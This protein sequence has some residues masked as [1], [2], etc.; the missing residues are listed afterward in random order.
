MP[1]DQEIRR[2][3]E[4]PAISYWLREALLSALERDPVD[5]ANDAGLLCVVLDKRLE[6]IL[7]TNRRTAN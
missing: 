6:M 1:N 2:L 3:C 5:A 7:N 4:D